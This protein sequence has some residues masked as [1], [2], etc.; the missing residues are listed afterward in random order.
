MKKDILKQIKEKLLK[1]KKQLETELK[2]IASG[3][4]YNPD[5]FKARFPNFGDEVDE[6]ANEVA[7]YGDRL[8]LEKALEKILKD[9]KGALER[10]RNGSY[11]KCK[12][13]GKEI[14][15]ARLLARPVSSAC[16]KCKEVLKKN[17]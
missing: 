11:G 1:R 16:V 7:A 10:I 5:D 12:Y 17:H 14:P 4:K 9:I 8:S 15:V 3:D 2:K 13:C 6:N